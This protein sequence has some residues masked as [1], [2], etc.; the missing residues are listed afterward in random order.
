[1]PAKGYVEI[2]SEGCKGCTLCVIHCPTKCLALNKSDTNSYGLHYAYLENEEECIACMN[3]AVICPD[4]AI[5]V[6]KK[7]S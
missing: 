2:S 3:C 4:A 5:T 6:F 1:M 7:V